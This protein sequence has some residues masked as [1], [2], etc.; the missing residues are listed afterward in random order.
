MCSEPHAW[1]VEDLG[2]RLDAQSVEKVS[3]ERPK[4]VFNAV[5]PPFNPSI[6]AKSKS[7]P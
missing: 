2:S 7:I 4:Q 1:L 5:S 6:T 3:V